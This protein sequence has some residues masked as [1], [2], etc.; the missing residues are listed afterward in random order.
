MMQLIAP[1]WVVCILLPRYAKNG[2]RETHAL[3]RYAVLSLLRAL[4]PQSRPGTH[5]RHRATSRAYT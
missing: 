5:R 1:P 3:S 2:R 4:I